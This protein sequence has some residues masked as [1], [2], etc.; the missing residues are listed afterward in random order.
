MCSGNSL[1]IFLG[2]PPSTCSSVFS[3]A[4][5]FYQLFVMML[6]IY[7]ILHSVFGHADWKHSQDCQPAGIN[8]I[9]KFF[10]SSLNLRN[11]LHVEFIFRKKNIFRHIYLCVGLVIVLFES[12]F[13]FPVGGRRRFLIKL[14]PRPHEQNVNKQLKSW[15]ARH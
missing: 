4:H 1:L 3:V 8:V 13:L 5:L 2:L 12:F 10:F 15:P 11:W 6:M 9:L 14:T 7:C